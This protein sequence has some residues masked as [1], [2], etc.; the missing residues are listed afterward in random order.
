MYKRQGQDYEEHARHLDY[1]KPNIMIRHRIRTYSPEEFAGQCMRAGA[2]Y[3]LPWHHS[4]ALLTGEDLNAYMEAVNRVLDEN[5][6]AG[7]AFNPEPYQWYRMYLG[8]EAR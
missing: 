6:Y 2:Q 5:G 7:K 8:I 1:V 3:I 4:N